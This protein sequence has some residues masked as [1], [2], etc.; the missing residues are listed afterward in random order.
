MN[1]KTKFMIGCFGIL[2]T[3]IAAATTALVATN[4][5]KTNHSIENKKV[6]LTS[7]YLSNKSSNLFTT[8]KGRMAAN[9]FFR[10]EN[11]NGQIDYAITN[12]NCLHII[13][14]DH[15][16]EFSGTNISFNESVL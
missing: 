12:D 9:A 11:I 10:G 16:S 2:S 3:S 5:A 8:T 6:D 14:Y 7:K 4:N 13:G 1:K 15:S